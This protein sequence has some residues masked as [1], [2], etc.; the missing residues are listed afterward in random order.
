MA[1]FDPTG[2]SLIYATYLGGAGD[3][4][5][6]GID[7]DKDGNVYL[8]GNTKSTNF[9]NVNPFQGTFGGGQDAFVVK[10]NPS[11][12]S[13]VYSTFLGGSGSGDRANGI[14]VDRQG[15]A[16]VVGTSNS[17]NFPTLNPFQVARAGG[18]EVF[19]TKLDTNGAG[20]YSTYFGGGGNDVGNGVA[21]DNDGNAYITGSTVSTNLPTLNPFQAARVAYDEAFVTKFNA[22]GSAL[23]FSTYI[24]GSRPDESKAIALDSSNNVYITGYS[25]SVDFPLVNPINASNAGGDDVFVVKLDSSGASIAYS[26]VIG[27]SGNDQGLGIAV[28]RNNVVYVTGE[29]RSAQFPMTDPTQAATGGGTSDAFVLTVAAAGDSFLYASYLGG[30][31]VDLAFGIDEDDKGNIVVV[32]NTNSANFPVVQPLQV[33]LAGGV[34]AFVAKITGAGPTPPAKKPAGCASGARAAQVADTDPMLPLLLIGSI[35]LLFRWRR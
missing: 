21:V 11:G 10:L 35:G 28:A 17:S 30:A 16:Y 2:S 6:S 27:G 25:E 18:T 9:P 31:G 32:G 8:A 20:V 14:A 3:D 34:D 7:V 33:A 13:I 29:T 19:V 22:D 23:V 24:G 4:G 26:T 12:S 15:N 5:F 1:K